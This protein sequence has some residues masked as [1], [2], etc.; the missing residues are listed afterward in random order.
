MNFKT[1]LATFMYGTEA[2]I[3]NG[4]VLGLKLLDDW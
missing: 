3:M 1:K 2:V 4:F